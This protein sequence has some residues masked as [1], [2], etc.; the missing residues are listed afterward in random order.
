M[1]TNSLFTGKALGSRVR[2]NDD[3]KIFPSAYKSQK[4]RRIMRRLDIS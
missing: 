3:K 2:G 4:S 1:P